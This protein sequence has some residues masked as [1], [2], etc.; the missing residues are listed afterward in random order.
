MTPRAP[1]RLAG[2]SAQGARPIG[3]RRASRA[4]PRPRP[5]GLCADGALGVPGPEAQRCSPSAAASQLLTP[6]RGLT[7]C[8][9]VLFE[10][11]VPGREHEMRLGTYEKP[12]EGA[13]ARSTGGPAPW[14]SPGRCARHPA[15]SPSCVRAAESPVERLGE[16]GTFRRVRNVGKIR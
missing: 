10:S 6:V 2:G 3:P 4:P 7:A 1:R 11:S 5:Q 16:W 15:P 14:G 13:E 8:S 9:G 12:R